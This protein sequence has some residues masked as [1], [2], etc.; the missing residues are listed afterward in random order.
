MTR[1]DPR[2]LGLT[3]STSPRGTSRADGVR[4]EYRAL[5]RGRPDQT[6]SE[7]SICSR[8][9][10]SGVE[11]YPGLTGHQR[12]RDLPPIQRFRPRGAPIASRAAARPGFEQR[13]WRAGYTQP[14]EIQRARPA[15]RKQ[16]VHAGKGEG[17][18]SVLRKGWFRQAGPYRLPRCEGG[19]WRNVSRDSESCWP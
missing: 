15:S 19:S 9:T 12:L 18:D 4:R 17:F 2:L 6:T 14:G 13:R 7:A 8:S 11:P 5:G 1:L 16:R 10:G 3:P